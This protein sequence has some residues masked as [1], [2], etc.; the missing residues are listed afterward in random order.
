VF[1]GE[2]AIETVLCEGCSIDTLLRYESS[3]ELMGVFTGEVAIETVLCEGCSI[4]TAALS[5]MGGKL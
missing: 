4:D 2:V 5:E 1:T 3:C